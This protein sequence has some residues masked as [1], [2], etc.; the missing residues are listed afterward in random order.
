MSFTA[1]TAMKERPGN[2]SRNKCIADLYHKC[3]ISSARNHFEFSEQVKLVIRGIIHPTSKPERKA[4]I[5]S[6]QD[7]MNEALCR[8]V[9]YTGE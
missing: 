8:K 2:A 7:S 6:D 9:K 5:D 3:P 1:I 4:S